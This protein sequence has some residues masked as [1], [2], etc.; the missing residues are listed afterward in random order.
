MSSRLPAIER[1]EQLLDLALQVFATKG[2]HDASMT[3]IAELAGVTK[4]VVYQHFESKRA[5][6]LAIIE[7]VGKQMIAEI[8]QATSQAPD[9]KSKAENGTV[10]FFRWVAKDVNSFKFLYDSGTRND[11]EFAEAVKRVTSSSAEAIAPLIAIDLDTEHL[12]TLAHGVVGASEG[13]A[14]HL[15]ATNQSFNPD[16]VGKQ[17]ADL[18][19]AGLRGV[20]TD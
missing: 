2:Y 5:L 16:V 3:D 7:N 8:A 11:P 14:R 15:I 18:L 13:V 1:K 12:R 4:P 19:W 20:G 17:V 9:G 10:A 6:F